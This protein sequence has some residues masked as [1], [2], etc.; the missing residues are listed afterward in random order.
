[1]KKQVQSLW[2]VSAAAVVLSVGSLSAQSTAPTQTPD[3]QSQSTQTPAPE[4]QP[5]Q[6][7]RPSQTPE[8]QQS[9][10]QQNQPPDTQ[11]QPAPS[12]AQ[13]SQPPDANGQG[14]SGSSAQSAGTQSF[15]GTVVKSGDKYVL[16]DEASGNTYDIDH[17]DEVQKFDGK[18][19]KVHGT[20]DA[21]GKMIHLQ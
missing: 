5:T 11:S 21:S 6:E 10:T 18:R 8:A 1:M 15:S 16:K 19:V 4:A 13:P 12:Q 9:Q 7:G 3:A 2:F 17:Q 14:A 20:L